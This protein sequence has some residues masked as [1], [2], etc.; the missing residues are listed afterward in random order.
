MTCNIDRRGRWARGI[1]GVL[2]IIGALIWHWVASDA[3]IWMN[4]LHLLIGL[5]GAFMIFQALAG[6]C[7]IRAMGFRTPL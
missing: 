5:V 6:W 4:L 1:P 7:A 3:G 2:L